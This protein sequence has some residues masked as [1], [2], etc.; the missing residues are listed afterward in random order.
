MADPIEAEDA[1]ERR[2][3][4][5]ALPAQLPTSASRFPASPRSDPAARA[6]TSGRVTPV[7]TQ[8]ESLPST[9]GR[10]T[11]EPDGDA[12]R[13]LREQALHA[14]SMNERMLAVPEWIRLHPLLAEFVAEAMGTYFLCLT[15]TLIWANMVIT[16]GRPET[17]VTS[18][19][20]G[21]MVASM[22]FTFAYISG[23][24]FNPAVSFAVFLARRDKMDVKRL[25]GY[26]ACQCAASLGA[27]V[28]AFITEGNLD[29]PI[30]AVTAENFGNR[31]FFSELIYTFALATVVL[32]VAYSRQ[33][34]SFFYGFA[35]GMLITAGD[36]AVGRQGA[37]FNPAIATGL[38]VASCL[39]GQCSAVASFWIYWVPPL[40]GAVL[41]SLFFKILTPP[42]DESSRP[43]AAQFVEMS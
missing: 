31:S 16:P 27:G 18:L 10:A 29:V 13:Q 38:Q 20:I 2:L 12:L 7:A 30:P 4:D 23:G 5:V 8:D 37:V 1:S 41:A 15:V 6:A 22:I 11:S 34:N 9:A 36:A 17:N 3:E 33:E 32:H 14:L 40:I 24:H 26:M 35:A 43:A 21:F 39:V 25:I 28:T 42:D 19:P